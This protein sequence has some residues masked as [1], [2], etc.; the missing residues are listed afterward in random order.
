VPA[1]PRVGCGG[2]EG[3]G[4]A[5]LRPASPSAP[6][7][8]RWQSSNSPSQP[9]TCW[10][11]PGEPRAQA[12]QLA[13][14]ESRA[15]GTMEPTGDCPP[16]TTSSAPCVAWEQPAGCS[17]RLGLV[18][19]VNVAGKHVRQVGSRRRDSVFK[20]SFSGSSFCT[21]VD[22]ECRLARKAALRE[23]PRFVLWWG[24]KRSFSCTKHA[25]KAR[26]PL[27]G[28]AGRGR[29]VGRCERGEPG[30]GLFP[31]A[32][33]GEALHPLLTADLHSSTPSV[34][35]LFHISPFS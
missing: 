8:V 4:W 26:I 23:F 9:G 10:V 3:P 21:A 35:S 28:L 5:S 29:G 13:P 12:L 30:I 6:A 34:T 15:L 11:L 1:Q 16:A 7:V 24:T 31:A 18:R 20:C 25:R 27:A 14:R 2:E 22:R 33:A 32:R 17:C 19:A